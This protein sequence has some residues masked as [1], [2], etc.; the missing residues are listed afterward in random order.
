MTDDL[1]HDALKGEPERIDLDKLLTSSQRSRLRNILGGTSVSALPHAGMGYG[2]HPATADHLLDIIDSLSAAVADL[3]RRA[4]IAEANLTGLTLDLKATGRILAVMKDQDED[5]PGNVEIV[6]HTEAGKLRDFIG[7]ETDW[8]QR[9]WIISALRAG[10]TD[11]TV[12]IE[13]T[14]FIDENRQVVELEVTENA[15]IDVYQPKG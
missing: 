14:R 4:D 3:I 9:R 12:K 13:L 6:R 8:Q 7:M 15:P 10:H 11:S 2:S 1:G 5:L